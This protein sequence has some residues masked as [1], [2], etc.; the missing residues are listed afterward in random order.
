MAARR[1]QHLVAA[2]GARALTRT[3]TAYGE[4]EL[5]WVDRFKYLGRVLSYD[6]SDTPAIC[7]NLN[8]WYGA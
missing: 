1:R 2:E 3:F 7:R 8:R 4:S 5:R 6:D